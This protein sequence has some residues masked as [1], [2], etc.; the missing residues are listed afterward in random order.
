MSAPMGQPALRLVGVHAE[1]RRIVE[2]RRAVTREVRAA[3][4]RPE[5]DPT[6]PRLRLAVQTRAH[7][8]GAAISPE[9]RERLLRLATRIGIRTFDAN[10]VIAIVQDEARRGASADRLEDRLR[11]IPKP[12]AS[13][14]RGLSVPWNIVTKA[15]AAIT[16]AGAMLTLAIRWM[17]SSL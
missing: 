13:S 9:R 1:D 3:A 14:R 5:L 15:A 4:I 11:V 2:A 10:L 17:T 8:Q 7:L 16:L 12:L 6:D